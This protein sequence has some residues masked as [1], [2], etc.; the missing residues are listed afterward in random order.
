MQT[1]HA[2]AGVDKAGRLQ[3]D[4]VPFPAVQPVQVFIST[5]THEAPQSLQ[6]CGL[7]YDQPFEPVAAAD[8]EV[9]Q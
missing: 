3:L 6:G 4:H 5:I 1:F 8:W 9:A 7:K 2:E